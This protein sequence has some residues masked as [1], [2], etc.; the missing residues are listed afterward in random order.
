MFW[1]LSFFVKY[2]TNSRYVRGYLDK[3]KRKKER[4]REREREKGDIMEPQVFFE[5]KFAFER[6][7]ERAVSE[8]SRLIAHLAHP[9]LSLSL[10]LSLR[11]RGDSCEIA[12][13]TVTLETSGKV[14]CTREKRINR[15]VIKIFHASQ[16]TTFLFFQLESRISLESVTLLRSG[17]PSR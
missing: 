14:R 16:A 6:R 10:S 9:S 8:K 1:K 3:R 15:P 17:I 2:R 11:V 12:K 4:E 7:V 5:N 13:V